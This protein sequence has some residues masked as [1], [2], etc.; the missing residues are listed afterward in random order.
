MKSGFNIRRSLRTKLLVSLMFITL[1]PLAI[2]NIISY[3]SVKSQIA[4]DVELRLSGLSR[5]VCKE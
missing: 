1:V 5:R 2:L 4:E 3:R